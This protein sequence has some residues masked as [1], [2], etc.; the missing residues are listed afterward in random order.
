MDNE[1]QTKIDSILSWSKTQPKFDTSF[2]LSVKTQLQTKEYI[3][4]K[5]QLAIDNII[6]EYKINF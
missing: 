2:I 1:Y 3:S 6:G 4:V 5:Q